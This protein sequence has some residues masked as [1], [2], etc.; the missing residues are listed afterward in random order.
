VATYTEY[1]ALNS[2]SIY[3]KQKMFSEKQ[4]DLGMACHTPGNAI[5]LFPYQFSGVCL[6][7]NSMTLTNHSIVTNTEIQH[8][9]QRAH[10]HIEELDF[11]FKC[12]KLHQ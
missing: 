10:T 7:L 9:G 12:C 11:C 2:P 5:E 8:T 3:K 4:K 6:T 1:L